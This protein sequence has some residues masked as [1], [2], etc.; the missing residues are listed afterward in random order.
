MVNNNQIP[1]PDTSDISGN[2]PRTFTGW[3]RTTQQDSYNIFECGRH[4]GGETFALG[5]WFGEHTTSPKGLTCHT[6]HGCFLDDV[7][8]NG[9]DFGPSDY[10]WHHFAHVWDG[11]NHYLY[12]DGEL[13]SQGPDSNE[14][15]NTYGNGCV[16]G[17]K[18]SRFNFIGD[19]K[20]LHV[21]N[22][23]LTLVQITKIK[24]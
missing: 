12:Y 19:V 8:K 6:W 10:V 7:G 4:I 13:S 3:W 9:K 18:D 15:L 16:F 21:Y 5:R 23:A 1:I 17:S 14:I 24:G 2:A 11:S 22:A 20:S